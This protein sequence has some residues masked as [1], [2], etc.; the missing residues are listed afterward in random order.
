[1]EKVEE[2]LEYFGFSEQS[3]H[4][5]QIE[6]SEKFDQFEYFVWF[7]QSEKQFHFFLFVG[8]V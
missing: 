7:M 4:Y 2:Q 3:E 6:K 1:M 8:V 5:E